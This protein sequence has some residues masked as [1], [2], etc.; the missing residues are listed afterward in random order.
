MPLKNVLCNSTENNLD[1]SNIENTSLE[2]YLD[3]TPQY[4]TNIRTKANMK[5][6][7]AKGAKSLD[8]N[9]FSL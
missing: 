6:F 5:I 4:L 1:I 7:Q 9:L 8:A 2:Y 3:I